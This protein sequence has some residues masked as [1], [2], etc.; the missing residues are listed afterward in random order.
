MLGRLEA[1][2]LQAKVAATAAELADARAATQVAA[3]RADAAE[4]ACAAGDA[5]VQAAVRRQLHTEAA[6]EVRLMY[7]CAYSRCDC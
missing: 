7:S 6:V 4:A 3:A 1:D 2:A 5:A